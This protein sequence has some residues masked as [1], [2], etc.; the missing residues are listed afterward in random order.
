MLP[1]RA[2]TWQSPQ[3]ST[4]LSNVLNVDMEAFI[5]V[6]GMLLDVSGDQQVIPV[7][8]SN[9]AFANTP[10]THAP[11]VSN[12]ALESSIRSFFRQYRHLMQCTQRQH[13][14]LGGEWRAPNADMQLSAIA[15]GY[16][17]RGWQ[18]ETYVDAFP[19]NQA[20]VD[21]ILDNTRLIFTAHD[22]GTGLGSFTGL[23]FPGME[24]NVLFVTSSRGEDSFVSAVIHELMHIF[25]VLHPHNTMA[26]Y[27]L[28]GGMSNRHIFPSAGNLEYCFVLDRML[29]NNLEELY[30]PRGTAMYWE[31]VFGLGHELADLWDAYHPTSIT[32]ADMLSAIFAK[33]LGAG[34]LTGPNTQRQREFREFMGVD[35]PGVWWR[36]AG[37]WQTYKSVDVLGDP[38]FFPDDWRQQAYE[39]AISL[40]QRLAHFPKSEGFLASNPW[41]NPVGRGD[42]VHS[43]QQHQVNT[44]D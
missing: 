21:F 18:A 32:Y 17:S 20:Y 2:V 36:L 27:A 11:F 12:G 5:D 40:I 35:V 41:M 34:A 6:D 4:V 44:S 9:P 15:A 29:L 24:Y 22:G 43:I 3:P 16:I 7:W 13:E 25:S 8:R 33:R 42:N 23:G 28:A 19:F 37:H 31:A 10:P 1:V 38:A 14:F 26:E 39:N 30:G